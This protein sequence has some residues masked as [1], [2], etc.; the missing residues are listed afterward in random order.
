MKDTWETGVEALFNFLLHY[1]VDFR[2]EEFGTWDAEKRRR[3]ETREER[4]KH[5]AANYQSEDARY[6]NGIEALHA[7]LKE[8]CLREGELLGLRP[9]VRGIWSSNPTMA[10]VSP[11]S[12]AEQVRRVI[13]FLVERVPYLSRGALEPNCDVWV[14]GGLV[15]LLQHD[16]PHGTRIANSYCDR[17][18]V[19]HYS[20]IFIS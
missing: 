13:I 12:R 4:R 11:Q 6:Q 16:D 9:T 3:R 15:K 14:L 18:L 7:E 19:Q 2:N 20:R 10:A 1:N 17:F 8:D 5:I